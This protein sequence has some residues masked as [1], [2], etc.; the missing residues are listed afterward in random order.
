M[1]YKFDTVEWSVFCI[2]N[3]MP[4]MLNQYLST[5]VS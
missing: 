2:V 3:Y 5:N 4:N 1:L